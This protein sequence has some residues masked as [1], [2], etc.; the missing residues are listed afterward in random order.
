LSP[1]QNSKELELKLLASPED[2]RRLRDSGLVA[3]YA[4]GPGQ[5]KHLRSVYYDTA[6]HSLAEQVYSLRVRYDGK[7]YVQ[8]LK[9]APPEEKSFSRHEWETPLHDSK[10]DLSRLPASAIG[11]VA[12]RLGA[13]ALVPVFSTLVTRQA[14]PLS[15]KGTK[16]E[17]AFD[18]GAI[19]A[20]GCERPL[21]EIEIELEKGEAA[22]LYELAL[23]LLDL[24][25]LRW[26]TASKFERGNAL[27]RGIPPPISKAPSSALAQ[28]TTLDDAIAA[29]LAGCQRH[30]L[31]NESAAEDGRD[32]EGVHQ[33]R[34][35]LRRMRAAF[36]LFRREL[37][38]ER[39]KP[40]DREAKWVAHKLGACRNWDVFAT[41]T[42]AEAKIEEAERPILLG[43][44][45]PKRDES[46]A[47][48]RKAFAGQRYARFQLSLGHWIECHGWRDRFD[49]PMHTKLAEPA[50][51]FAPSS[52]C[53]Q[54][55]K[56]RKK[57]M[58][59]DK[60]KLRNRHRLRVALKELRYAVEFFQP[61]FHKDKVKRH[62]K[63]LA[64]LQE[65]LGKDSDAITTTALL[66]ELT[67]ATSSR[68]LLHATRSLQK[69]QARERHATAP[70]ARRAWVK[71]K[72][73]QPFW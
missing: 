20:G 56:V 27:A 13:K 71:F 43:A 36:A 30:L 69:W 68:A 50:V 32:P 1:R 38:T 60:L 63:K 48:L 66:Q 25:P 26:S 53:A 49:G 28:D 6:E 9:F 2:L 3:R 41:E 46:Y 23:E 29:T 59:F 58:G 70:K 47:A 4:T 67:G 21:S 45:E 14:I 52:L 62:E 34:V 51:K 65:L 72:N 73:M 33:M 44:A 11:P 7:T 19:T 35:A 8:T 12:A 57:G 40:Y 42:L 5:E 37:E 22:R 10:P 24:A 55:R 54:L 15:F 61:L 31:A 16:L 39:F 64:L 17:L 18:Q